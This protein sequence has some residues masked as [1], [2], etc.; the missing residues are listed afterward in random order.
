MSMQLKEEPPMR[1]AAQV[2]RVRRAARRSGQEAGPGCRTLNAGDRRLF[3]SGCGYD[4]GCVGPGGVGDV[5][6][7]LRTME[8][9][10][11]HYQ[12]HSHG[13]SDGRDLPLILRIPRAFLSG[14]WELTPRLRLFAGSVAKH[15][16][17]S[18]S[19]IRKLRTAIALPQVVRSV[20]DATLK[21]GAQPK[22]R[23]EA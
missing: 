22:S 10:R 4:F 3:R 12:Q 11:Q 6:E 17:L 20:S 14:G 8:Q 19:Q 23:R 9:P 13:E 7:T 18:P 16:F 15:P 2:V 1:Q 21:V 5:G